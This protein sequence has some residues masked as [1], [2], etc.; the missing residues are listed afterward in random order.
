MM[1]IKQIKRKLSLSNL[2]NLTACKETIYDKYKG[3]PAE[4]A[5]DNHL[6][7]A[8]S[9]LIR[10]QDATKSGGVSWGYSLGWNPHFKKKGWQPA[11]PEVTGYIIP[12]F[13]DYY[14]FTNHLDYFRR[15]IRMADWEIDVQMRNGAVQG[16][17]INEPPSPA[18]FNTGQ[19]IQGWM[20]AFQETKDERYIDVSIRAADFLLK[21]QDADGAWRKENSRFARN[22]ATTYNSRVGFSL[23][24]LSDI[25]NEP[26][27][28]QAGAKN[29]NYS[30]HQ[31]LPNGWFQNNCLSDPEAPLLHTI[32][33]AAEGILDA[34]VLLNNTEYLASAQKTADVLLEKLKDNGSISGRFSSDWS[35]QVGWSCLTG[36]AQLA[37]IWLKLY[38]IIRDKKYYEAAERA[39]SFLK[40]IQNRTTSNMGLRGG[41]KGSFPFDGEYGKYQILSWPAKFFVDALLLLSSISS[42]EDG[43][44]S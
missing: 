11:Y 28:Y 5:H 2:L 14:N 41:I 27:Y 13:F 12:T 7:E 31:Q 37:V 22:D 36:N 35:S 42:E 40:K 16:G 43:G 33:Y 38:K 30:I 34:G 23:I 44:K 19:V 20:R 26:R 18:V 9:W 25:L 32:C 10:A 29:I 1:L 8:M 39:I 15:A 4:T 21:A 6:N 24:Q 3:H 17:T